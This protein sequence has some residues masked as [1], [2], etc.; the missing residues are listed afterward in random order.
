M[1]ED[2]EK[3]FDL[4]GRVA[5]IT[6][7]A[8]GI[9]RGTAHVLVKAGATIVAADINQ[10]GLDDLVSE[11]GQQGAVRTRRTDVSQRDELEALGDFA[12]EAFGR[13]DIWVNS[14]G[15]LINKPML[16]V[17]QDDYDRQ[18]K[19]NQEGVYWGTIAAARRMTDKGSI[20]NLSSNGADMAVPG[21]SLYAASKSAVAMISRSAAAEFGPRNIRVNT[22]APGFIE[23]EMVTYRYR[24][25]NGVIDEEVR[26][27]ILAERIA[28][29]PLRTTGVPLDI[30]MSILYL[31]A[32]ASRYV[33]GQNIRV[34]GGVTMS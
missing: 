29:A 14:A 8:S 19:I 25:A 20:I 1:H 5:V 34:N 4:T 31:A 27:K 24:D 9:G 30:A 18:L 33:T 17:T 10:A 13:V 32:D 11:I 16:E 2:L 26:A 15:I 12:I 7:A 28:G 6:G 22:I 23:T 3:L 21:I